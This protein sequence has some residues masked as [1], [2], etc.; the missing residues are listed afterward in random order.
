LDAIQRN[1]N[2]RTQK[3]LP[4]PEFMVKIESQLDTNYS[5]IFLE[6]RFNELSTFCTG[7]AVV[8]NPGGT[9]F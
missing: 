9:S 6:G 4:I 8:T 3:S 7:M 5:L 1:L 2:P